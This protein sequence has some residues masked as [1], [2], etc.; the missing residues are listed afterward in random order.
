MTMTN[1]SPKQG[2][3]GWARIQLKDGP[4]PIAENG[5]HTLLKIHSKRLNFT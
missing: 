3:I 1:F 5:N 2:S 4:V